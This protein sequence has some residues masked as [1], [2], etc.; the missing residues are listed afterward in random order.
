MSVLNASDG[1]IKWKNDSLSYAGPCILHNDWIF[2]NANSYSESAGAFHLTDGRPKMVANPLT[3]EPQPWKLTRAYGCNNI[4]ASENLLTFRSGAA[5]FYD[6]VC[7]SGT[8]NFGG[9]KSGCTSNLVVANGVLNAPDYT[10]T[11]SCSYQ[12][13]TSLALVHMPELD[14]WTI[15]PSASIHTTKGEL[16]QAGIN[17]GAPGDRRDGDVLWLEYP[18]VGGPSP[19]LSVELNQE[20]T[21]FR[22]HSSSIGAE[23]EPWILASGVENVRKVSIDLN[24]EKKASLKDGIPVAHEH[25]DAEEQENGDVSRGSSD[26]ELVR[27]SGDQIIGIRFN[28]IN[29]PRGAEIRSA[30]IQMTCDETS[31]EPTTLLIAAQDSGHADRFSGDKH[32]ISSRAKTRAEVEWSPGPWKKKGE[33]GQSQRT[34]DLAPLIR[35]VINR[36]DWKPGN[37][38]AFLISG[39]GKRV[40]VSSRGKGDGAARLII[41]A[42]KVHRDESAEEPSETYRLRL[43]FAAPQQAGDSLRKFDVALQGKTVIEDVTIDPSGKKGER[44]AVHTLDNVSL[45]GRLELEFIPKRGEPVLS[46]IEIVRTDPY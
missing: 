9:F 7:D 5:G 18:A 31:D 11:C 4:I 32:D 29:L 28:K 42:D 13:Q 30:Y 17:F 8:G 21:F 19:P 16:T 39:T 41:D 46:G 43:F 22:H 1:T 20:A 37:S 2:T 6:L 44:F 36:N 24:L 35:E 26:L 14:F 23:D 45:P 25:D 38:L 10:R 34:P 27:D 15:H 12:N 40:A 3:G 33:S